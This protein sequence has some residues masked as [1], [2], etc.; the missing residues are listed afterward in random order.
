[1]KHVSR[2]GYRTMKHLFRSQVSETTDDFYP[3]NLLLKVINNNT[4]MLLSNMESA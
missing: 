4:E 2:L 3:P 1:L